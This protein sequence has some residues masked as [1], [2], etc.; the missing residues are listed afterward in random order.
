MNGKVLGKSADT[1]RTSVCKNKLHL[2]GKSRGLDWYMSFQI[3]F[4]MHVYMYKVN[5]IFGL[6]CAIELDQ[7]QGWVLKKRT[8]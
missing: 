2:D 3:P 5:I 6:E 7:H 8:C 4:G 1:K